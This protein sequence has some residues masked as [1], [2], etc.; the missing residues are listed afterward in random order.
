VNSE[1]KGQVSTDLRTFLTSYE[2]TVAGLH[3]A[4]VPAYEKR[5]TEQYEYVEWTGDVI[6]FEDVSDS[7]DRAERYYIRVLDKANPRTPQN[8]LVGFTAYFADIPAADQ[9]KVAL[10]HKVTI[11]G[12]L[13]RRDRFAKVWYLKDSRIV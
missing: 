6:Q 11:R 3:P 12:K 4:N 9:A 8:A 2:L 10:D 1:T 7:G 5:L 13:W